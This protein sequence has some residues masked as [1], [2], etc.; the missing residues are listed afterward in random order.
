MYRI[1]LFQNRNP[2]PKPPANE[3]EPG[4]RSKIAAAII[5]A[6]IVAVTLLAGD[7]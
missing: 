3:K 2:T 6:G 7:A 1:L 4:T 5:V